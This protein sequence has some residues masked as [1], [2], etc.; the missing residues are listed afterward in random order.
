MSGK[1]LTAA[2]TEEL[3]E[4]VRQNDGIYNQSNPQYKDQIW[5][6][7]IWLKI[8]DKMNVKD[9]TGRWRG[10]VLQVRQVGQI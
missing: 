10:S 2:K 1:A 6:R 5:T 9:I 4:L 3:I 8:A 7:N